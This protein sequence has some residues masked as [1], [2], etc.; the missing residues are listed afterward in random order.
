M[1]RREAMEMLLANRKKV[2]CDEMKTFGEYV[3]EES[4]E[5]Y[6]VIHFSPSSLPLRQRWRNTGLSADFLAE[7]W[8]TFFPDS[9]RLTRRKQLEAKESIRF[10]AN[11]LL[12]NL[13]KFSY[14]SVDYPVGLALYLFKGEF[15]FYASNVIDPQSIESF[16]ARIEEFLTSD[17]DDLYIRQVGRNVTEEGR[18]ESH[19]G[20]LTMARDY[21]GQLAW[22]FEALSGEE[23][24]FTVVTTMVRLVI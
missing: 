1:S 24:E 16:Q 23:S 5:E 10:V 19:L 13:M 9:S 11:E 17:L 8:S 7:Y 4:S 6:L 14:E 2:E 12:E 20:L 18:R 3:E 15:R 22:K 21:S